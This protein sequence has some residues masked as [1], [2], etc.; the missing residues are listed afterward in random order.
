MEKKLLLSNE[1]HIYLR[2]PRNPWNYRVIKKSKS[3]QVYCYTYAY[4]E[5][6]IFFIA[7]SHI[8]FVM[9]IK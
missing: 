2:K 1:F 4:K 8:A 6:N 5:I 9:Q 7:L 3:T